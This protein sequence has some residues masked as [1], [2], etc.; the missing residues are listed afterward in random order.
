MPSSKVTSRPPILCPQ[1]H[2]LHRNLTGIESR[3][4]GN[5]SFEVL[6]Q[7]FSAGGGLM[8]FLFLIFMFGAEQVRACQLASGSAAS[9]R[10]AVQ[11]V[12]CWTKGLGCSV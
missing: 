4:E 11:I 3:E 7:Y 12:C 8:T 2:T 6:R 9:C 10:I 5:L 1:P